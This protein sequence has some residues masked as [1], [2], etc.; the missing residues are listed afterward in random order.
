M[1]HRAHDGDKDVMWERA[2][3]A[4]GGAKVATC[5]WMPRDCQARR[6]LHLHLQAWGEGDAD[7]K[8]ICCM[9]RLTQRTNTFYSPVVRND[10]DPTV[11][12][13]SSL[14]HAH[15]VVLPVPD[16]LLSANLRHG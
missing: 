5:A 4:V 10:A 6:H 2:E 15:A 14:L 12:S 9:T 8:R 1:H 16:D 11:I 3:E 7:R 13:H